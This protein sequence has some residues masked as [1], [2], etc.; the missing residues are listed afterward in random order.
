M[1]FNRGL[2]GG[3]RTRRR[4]VESL[5]RHSLDDHAALAVKLRGV[6][7]RG[8]REHDGAS[9]LESLPQFMQVHLDSARLG[10]III[11]H[12]QMARHRNTLATG[13]IELIT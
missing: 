3:E 5:R 6:F 10:R 7:L 1:A 11:G 12:Q 8:G 2:N 4:C 9:Y 13:D